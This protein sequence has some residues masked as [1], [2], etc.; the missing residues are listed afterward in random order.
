[1]EKYTEEQVLD[2]TTREK[3]AIEMLK[4][5][6]LTPSA[7]IHKVNVGN[8]VFGDKVTPYLADTRYIKKGDEYV[9]RDAKETA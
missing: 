2:I 6:K 5:L 8:D 1:M 3:K 9:E 7:I 4:E